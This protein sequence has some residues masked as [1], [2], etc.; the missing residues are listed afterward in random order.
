MRLNKSTLFFKGI[1]LNK[2]PAVITIAYPEFFGRTTFFL[3]EK[4]IEV[5]DIIEAAIICYF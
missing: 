5:G 4:A 3:F 2:N 1:L